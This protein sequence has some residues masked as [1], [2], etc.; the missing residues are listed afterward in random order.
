MGRHSKD[1]TV[2]HVKNA[3]RFMGLV[4]LQLSGQSL[5][6]P[7][8]ARSLLDEWES[9][10]NLIK[11]ETRHL[12]YRLKL[13]P[14]ETRDA[15]ERFITSYNSFMGDVHSHNKEAS[16]ILSKTVRNTIGKVNGFDL[17]ENQLSSIAMDVR[18]RLVLAG[19]GTGKTAT[20]V[21][22]VKYLLRSGKASP[23]DILVLS[24]TNNAVNELSSRI[25]SE[26]GIRCD[27]T[28]F[29]RLGLK[30]IASSEGKTP[31]I[32]DIDIREFVSSELRRCM[33]DPKMMKNITSYL[34]SSCMYVGDE[35]DFNDNSTY[36]RFIRDNPL[37]TLNGETV[38]SYG[39]ADIAN[40]LMAMGIPYGYETPYPVDTRDVDHVQYRPDFHIEGTDVYIEYFGIDRD[41]DV[42][43]FMAGKNGSR[44]YLDQM[45]WKRNLHQENGTRLISLYA[46]QRSEGTLIENLD[47][48]LDRLGVDPSPVSQNDIYSRISGG[49]DGMFNRLSSHVSEAI[50]LLKGASITIDELI[51]KSRGKERMEL[52]RFASILKPIYESYQTRLKQTDSID[53]EDMINIAAE[54]VERGDIHPHY[55]YIIIDEYQDISC[56]RVRLISALKRPTD[57]RLF[58]VG[59]DWQGIYSFNGSDV[60]YT[61]G[62]E[63]QW[64]P[65]EICRLENTYRF[66][67]PLLEMSNGFMNG[68]KG[69]MDKVLKGNGPETSVHFIHG[70]DRRIVSKKICSALDS[71]PTGQ[72]I[73][74]IGRHRHD[75]SRL[76]TS[77]L[78]W[79]P[80]ISN[81]YYKV[82]YSRRP[83]LDIRFMT[84]HGSKGLEADDVF[85]INNDRGADGFPDL[86][87]G[88][89]VSNMLRT[90][91]NTDEER[92]MMYVAMTRAKKSLHF[93]VID[94][95]E[96]T[97]MDE[98]NYSRQNMRCPL[99]GGT[100]V[101]REGKYGRFYGCSNFSKGCRYT[102]KP[103][104]SSQ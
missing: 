28:T 47:S 53:F 81:G 31:N 62:F 64:G 56:S 30:T 59:D 3:E 52:K 89:P 13:V 96:S 95:M 44:D 23:E 17:D 48:E 38:K 68:R 27:V 46:Y 35:S 43:P 22:L 58:C 51:E 18:N 39:E 97:F 20:V 45:E 90:G 40:H 21:G 73:L 15:F 103:G 91:S 86:R 29:H 85:I 16:R 8:D 57:A 74:F 1:N 42:A 98:L 88:N 25:R 82:T 5:I 65:S 2:D 12:K 78:Q 55:R 50:L 104:D 77:L 80:D 60:G 19:A 36:N 72:S 4:S 87:P 54:H 7:I 11:K 75:V 69:Q 26:T 9:E 49:K 61:T 102:R 32:S 101:L 41:G 93:V 100:L 14:K 63:E 10:H 34:L 83:D 92:R 24:F 79:K 84:V 37:I 99:C 6:D 94:G 70:P 76:D 66:N 33:S 71:I 67:G